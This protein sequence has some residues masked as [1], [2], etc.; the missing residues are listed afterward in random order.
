MGTKHVPVTVQVDFGPL[1]ARIGARYV[2]QAKDTLRAVARRF[3]ADP[4]AWKAIAAAN[5][6]EVPDPDRLRVGSV[7]YVPPKERLTT[8]PPGTVQPAAAPAPDLALVWVTPGRGNQ[9]IV[10]HGEGTK[11]PGAVVGSLFTVCL[12]PADAAAPLLRLKDG[13]A[14]PL[15][16][17][18]ALPGVASY[19]VPWPDA[20]LQEGDP[21]SRL[22]VQVRVKGI[23]GTRIVADADVVRFGGD[24]SVVAQAPRAPS[25]EP[26]PE[27]IRIAAVPDLLPES[28]PPPDDGEKRFPVPIALLVAA[29]GL[30]V[31]LAAW[32]FRSKPPTPPAA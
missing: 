32:F 2:V 12:V 13:A 28:R 19:T 14:Q 8:P 24:G 3:S 1:A 25:A 6:A 29:G 30:L 18:A 16:S 20:N 26:T 7:L 4:A 22:E 17:T 15:G 5:Q 9:E 27:R 23:D 11:V 31:L 10:R 21:T